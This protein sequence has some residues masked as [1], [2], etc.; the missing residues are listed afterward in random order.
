MAYSFRDSFWVG[1]D[2][3]TKIELTTLVSN[4]VPFETQTFTRTSTDYYKPYNEAREFLTSI[5]GNES[6]RDV[7]IYWPLTSMFP[8]SSNFY[9]M[10]KILFPTAAPMDNLLDISGITIGRIPIYN[11]SPNGQDTALVWRGRKNV[12]YPGYEITADTG[13]ASC[14]YA[15]GVNH[16]AKTSITVKLVFIDPDNIIDGTLTPYPAGNFGL[17]TIVITINMDSAQL[18]TQSISIQ[19]YHHSLDSYDPESAWAGYWVGR[20][21]PVPNDDPYSPG[22]TSGGGGGDGSFNNQSTPVDHPGLPSISLTDTGFLSLYSPTPSQVKALANYMWG[23]LFSIETFKKLFSD[24]MQSILSLHAVPVAVQKGSAKNVVLGNVS[25][26]IPM[27]TVSN[28]WVQKNCGALTLPAYWGAYLDFDPYTH[29][30]LYLPYIGTVSISAD[31]VISTTQ[32]PK[33]LSLSYNFD[34]LSG[35][36]VATLKSG[37]TVLYNF[38]GS[39]CMQV[40]FTS[41]TY[42]NTLSSLMTVGAGIAGIVATKGAGAAILGAVGNSAAAVVN[43]QKK[44]VSHGGSFGGAG[45]FLGIQVPYFILTRPSLCL[46]ASQN[47]FLGYP[48]FTTVELASLSGFTRVAEIHLEGVPATKDELA[49]LDSMLKEGVI[50]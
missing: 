19:D 21:L 11:A 42:G 44:D 9:D 3:N 39:A 5:F 15:G 38:Q 49:E 43:A 23:D 24:P 18:F 20:K 33:E 8:E 40:P 34:V 1:T 32:S 36:C 30:Q 48:S 28:Q 25:T 17:S 31:D 13:G 14:L 46:P 41:L 45:G 27:P 10:I 7:Q 2:P 47:E 4:Y 50:L 6:W 16:L 22:G 35:A 29:L 37:G 26:D 12:T